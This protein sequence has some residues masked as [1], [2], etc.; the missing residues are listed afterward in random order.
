MCTE[1]RCWTPLTSAVSVYIGPTSHVKK[2]GVICAFS[3][4]PH[5]EYGKIFLN[6]LGTFGKPLMT[7]SLCWLADLPCRAPEAESCISHIY[8]NHS[9][10]LAAK[11][12]THCSF[13][14]E[15]LQHAACQVILAC[16]ADRQHESPSSGP[17]RPPT[18]PDMSVHHHSSPLNFASLPNCHRPSYTS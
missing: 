15:S 18:F 17:L 11:P 8:C 13:R 1:L 12:V 3:S 16:F 10:S 14:F 4:A 7:A 9:A 2:A 5:F 6:Q